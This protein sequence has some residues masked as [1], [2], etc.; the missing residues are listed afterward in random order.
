[1]VIVLVLVGLCVHTALA[2]P[3]SGTQQDPWRIESLADFDEFA[4]DPNYWSG[5]TRLETDVNLAGRTYSIAVIAPDT[6]TSTSWF[7][8]TAFTGIFDGNAHKIVWLTIDDGGAGNDFLGLF[9]FIIDD[10]EIRNLGVEGGSISGD[11]WVGGLV[12]LNSGSISN[13]YSTADVSGDWSVGGLVGTNSGSP[14]TNCYSTGSV[15][16]IVCVGGLVGINDFGSI[17]DCYSTSSVSGSQ[18]VGGLL[19]YNDYGSL[20][21]CYSTGTV[22]GGGYVGGLM[23]ANYGTLTNCYYSGSVSGN[24]S[25]G[26]L[27][28]CNDSMITGCHSTGS[29][30]GL[31]EVGGLV[32]ENYRTVTNCYSTASVI[33]IEN[34]EHE[35]EYD[36]GGLV[37][38][39]YEGTMNNC[40]SLGSV[41]GYEDVGGLVGSNQ[42]GTI[43]D[44]YST[45]PVSAHHRVGGL[46]GR[47]SFYG[48]ITNCYST[49]SLLAEHHVGGLIGYKDEDGIDDI[50]NSFWDIETSDCNTS[51]GGTP[52]TTEEMKTR[53]TFTDAGWDFIEIWVIAENQTYPYLRFAP[54]G[55]LNYDKNVDLFDLAI[56]TSHWLEEN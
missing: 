12:G 47:N 41:S 10:G 27:T 28:G 48:T 11:Y 6:D 8:G 33:G 53:S 24:Y 32:G 38:Q 1:M 39:N 52:K 21:Y 3:G 37:G 43:T 5:F 25:V 56:L 22:S 26:G 40:Y 44:C 19:G 31:R 42:D 16:G 18:H 30:A 20:T 54:A 45:G 2:L 17:S 15:S 36:V 29:I 49:G 14:M 9:G 34:S 50:R 13:C 46:V 23:G 4:A 51:A 55:D 7:E 35:N